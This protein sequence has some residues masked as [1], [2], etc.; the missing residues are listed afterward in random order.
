VA[1]TSSI[2]AAISAQFLARQTLA[3][4]RA[5]NKLIPLKVSFFEIDQIKKMYDNIN[6]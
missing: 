2:N 5:R 6:T 1:F 4:G 3:H